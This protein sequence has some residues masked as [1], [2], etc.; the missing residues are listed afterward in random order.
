MP[1]KFRLCKLHLN[2]LELQ[3][4][5]RVR[6]A[7]T[8]SKG[9]LGR[10]STS[11]KRFHIELFDESTLQGRLYSLLQNVLLDF[12]RVASQKGEFVVVVLEVRVEVN[13]LAFFVLSV[14][15]NVIRVQDLQQSLQV[16]GL[17]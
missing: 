3:E 4:R 11:Q 12:F 2:S 15:I 6:D 14:L 9:N 13:I 1:L 5:H 10:V 16:R 8:T 17:V 7:M